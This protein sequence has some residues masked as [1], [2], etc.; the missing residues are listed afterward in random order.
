MPRG[1][2]SRWTTAAVVAVAVV[3]A[4]GGVVGPRLAGDRSTDRQ[5]AA[6]TPLA[7]VP[8]G[9]DDVSGGETAVAAPA[10]A[11]W[12]V[13]IGYPQSPAGVRAAAVAWV[14]ALGDLMRMGPIARNDTLGALLSQRALTDTIDSFDAERDRFR[15]E[16]GRDVSQAV[17]FDA[18]LAVEIVDAEP[19]RAVVEVWS[20]LLFGTVTDRVEVLW[21]THVVTLLWERGSWRVDEVVRRDGP[22]PVAATTS[23]PSTGADFEDVTGWVPAVLAGTS[24]G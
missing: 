5:E 6:A 21:R 7:P 2:R 11:T 3:V 24:I 4:V 1:E 9:S 10:A 17:W 20:A 16:F 15:T 19:A 12:G 23:M 8:P 13:P 22:T 18:P 14:A